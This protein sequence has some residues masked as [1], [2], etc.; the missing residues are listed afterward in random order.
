MHRNTKI[1]L[2]TP[3]LPRF[4]IHIEENRFAY[5][6]NEKYIELHITKQ[7]QQDLQIVAMLMCNVHD[8]PMSC[9][10]TTSISPIN[11]IINE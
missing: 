9:Y 5:S 6:E 4:H 10:T 11:Q 2:C 8:S 7:Q 3:I 1:D